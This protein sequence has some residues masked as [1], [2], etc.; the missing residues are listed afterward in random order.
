[1]EKAKERILKV[2]KRK[3][4]GHIQKNPQKAISWFFCRNFAGQKG[5]AWYIHS[6]KRETYNLG[7]SSQQD[8]PSEL[9]EI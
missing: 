9:K 2:A 8:Y 7:Y 5:V 6:S 1:M 4:E 3:R